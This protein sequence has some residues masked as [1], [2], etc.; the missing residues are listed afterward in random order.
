[1]SILNAFTVDLEDWYHG[2]TSTNRKPHLWPQLESRVVVNTERL[3]DL[4]AAYDVRTTVF[5]LGDVAE[6]YPDLIR[7]V[8]AAGHEVG[9]HGYAHA[10]I[11]RLTRKQFE[12][13]LIRAL[14]VLASLVSQPIIGH[15][16]PYFSIDRS[17]LWALDI[18]AERGFVYD[19]SVFPTRNML[20]GYPGAPRFPYRLDRGRGLIEFPASTVRLLGV[21]WPISGG[22]YVRTLPYPVVRWAI[23]RLNRQGVP[24]I[25]Y[26]H[27]WELDIEQP[28]RAA[29]LRE[30]I[31]HYHGRRSLEA[32]L[33]RLFQDFEFGPLSDL[34]G[35]HRRDLACDAGGHNSATT[36]SSRH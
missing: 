9:V 36:A 8:A 19:S 4:L 21:T 25:M 30:R 14:D 12:T 28:M 7:C 31:T 17:T 22:F 10:D 16:A 35:S 5:V 6:Q 33:R 1:M 23:K 20:Y 26:L 2:L 24:A 18:V 13:E 32:K 3:L 11:R 34:V 15:R 27:P 29:T